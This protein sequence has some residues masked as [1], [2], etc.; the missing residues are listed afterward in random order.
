MRKALVIIFDSLAQEF[1]WG[2]IFISLVM[3][4]ISTTWQARPE[5]PSSAHLLPNPV[6]KELTDAE[7]S[8]QC[9]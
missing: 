2:L 9:H 4:F 5:V 8:A 6:M 7:E 1:F 3:H